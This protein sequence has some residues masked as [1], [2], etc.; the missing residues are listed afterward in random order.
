ML[1]MSGASRDSSVGETS[2]W[3]H[4]E[5]CF[6]LSGHGRAMPSRCV[7]LQGCCYTLE[8]RSEAA[9]ALLLFERSEPVGFICWPPFSLRPACNFSSLPCT[10]LL[11]FGL[12]DQVYG[13]ECLSFRL[14]AVRPDSGARVHVERY[15]SLLS[16]T[17]HPSVFPTP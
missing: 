12:L 13:Q 4:C 7:T 9:P 3:E 1:T 16:S 2:G 11:F 8:R 15:L 17:W 5:C 14:E 6:G 10:L